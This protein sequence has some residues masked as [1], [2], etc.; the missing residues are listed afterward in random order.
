VSE[1]FSRV[2]KIVLAQQQAEQDAAH[3][4]GYLT[5]EDPEDPEDEDPLGPRP[6]WTELSTITERTELVTE[7]SPAW[8]SQNLPQP[9][10][11]GR[12][13][14][15]SSRTTSYGEELRA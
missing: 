4:R 6:Y 2:P 10:R 9:S 3:E 11:R 5:I 12:A 15:D 14:L 8:Q 1:D 13:G 7:P